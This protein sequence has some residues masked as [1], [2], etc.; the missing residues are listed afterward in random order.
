MKRKAFVTGS[1]GMDGAILCEKLLKQDYEVYGLVRRS[2]TDNTDNINHIINDI[3]V[4]DG[5]LTDSF[6]I[7][8]TIRLV[9]PDRVFNTAAMSH[10]GYSFKNPQLTTE[11]NYLGVLNLL[12]AIRL[13][14]PESRFIQASTSEMFGGVYTEPCNEE[15]V[16]YP[17]SPYAVAKAAAHYL[18]RNY[19]EAYNLFAMCAICFNHEHTTRGLQFVTRKATRSAAKIKLGMIEKVG[20]GN[21]ETYRDWGWA[22][23]YMD[24]WI[25]ALDYKEP[26]EFVFATGKTHCIK[27]MLKHVFEYAGLGDYKNYV[28]RDPKFYRPSDVNVLLGDASKAKELLGWEP[29]TSFETMIENMY[30]NDY[31]DLKVLE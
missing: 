5:E 18:V 17:L 8:E 3:E 30:D 26:T 11:V 1:T 6:L 9:K 25:K 2:A 13:H 15:T 10:V 27:D 28:Y 22:P 19:R 12:E 20:F 16:L 14:S 29:T 31:K 24:G 4:I 23:D 21:I 7:G